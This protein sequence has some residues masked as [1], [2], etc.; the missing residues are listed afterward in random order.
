MPDVVV[1]VGESDLDLMSNM[2]FFFLF[3]YWIQEKLTEIETEA[4]NLLLARHKAQPQAFPMSP[5]HYV[6]SYSS[7]YRAV[8]LSSYITLSPRLFSP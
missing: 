8:S 1:M 5:R 2:D 7:I 3:Q 6:C 4:D